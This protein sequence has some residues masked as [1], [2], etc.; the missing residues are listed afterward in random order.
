MI[1]HVERV[2]GFTALCLVLLLIAVSFTTFLGYLS[3]YGTYAQLGI[4]LAVGVLILAILPLLYT[5]FIPESRRAKDRKYSVGD[6]S[7]PFS[8]SSRI[9]SAEPT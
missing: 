2:V 8:T 6:C 9:L 4:G 1:E 3:R 7:K 5:V